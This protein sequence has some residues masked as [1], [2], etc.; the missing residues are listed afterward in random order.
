MARWSITRVMARDRVA[1]VIFVGAIFASAPLVTITTGCE[2]AAPPSPAKA[3]AAGAAPAS[4]GSAAAAGATLPKPDNLPLLDPTPVIWSVA[5]RAKMLHQDGLEALKS[6]DLAAALAGIAAAVQLDPSRTE[7]HLDLARLYL[8]G[9]QP[10]VAEGILTQLAKDLGA[11]GGCIEALRAAQQDPALRSLLTS[12]AG[13]KIRA[14]L[15]GQ[16]LAWE[17]WTLQVSQSLADGTGRLLPR[18][19]HPRVPFTL[20]RSCPTC[21]NPARRKPERRALTGP[22]VAVKLA[23]RFNTR[24]KRFG[25]IPLRIQ[26]KGS[27]DGRCT[28]WPV[29]S[30]VPVGSAALRRLCFRPI[31]RDR[32]ALT[33]VVL[34]YGRSRADVERGGGGK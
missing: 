9:G 17:E 19:I 28:Q 18:F 21:S 23:S 8:R 25:G 33:E 24:E 11:C 29:P 26:G 31:S 32:A 30:P 2:R 7:A 4:T 5:R 13:V 10:S 27:R 1:S 22:R 6:G 20:V 34:V 12:A 14:A 16:T 3:S 15:K